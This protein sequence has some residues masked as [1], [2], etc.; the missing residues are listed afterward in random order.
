MPKIVDAAR[1]FVNWIRTAPARSSDI[2][3]RLMSMGSHRNKS[4]T[5]PKPIAANLRTFS[6]TPCAR[7]AINLIKNPIMYMDWEIQPKKNVPMN[8]EV[9]RQIRVATNCFMVPNNDDSFASFVEKIIED[10]LA[11]SAGAYEQQLGDDPTHPLWMWPV[12]GQSIQQYAMWDGSGP[13]YKQVLSRD[14]TRGIDLQ[15]EELVYITPN[16]STETPYGYGPLEIT[17]RSISRQ[18][19]AA[20]F[21]GNVAS[22]SQPLN[23]I[24]LGDAGP[25]EVKA[26]RS[27]WRD[28]VEGQGSTPLVGNKEK[29]AVLKLAGGDD[30]ALYLKWQE[31]LIAEIARGFDLSVSSFGLQVDSKNAGKAQTGVMQ[32]PNFKNAVVP[33]AMKVRDFINRKSIMGRLGF[34]QIELNWPAINA[35]DRKKQ[36]EI[37]EVRYQNNMLI[38]NEARAA[39]GKEPLDSE[40]GDMT[41][42]E[43]QIA[44]GEARRGNAAGENRPGILHNQS[45]SKTRQL[46]RRH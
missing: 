32:D 14:S 24:Y 13:R 8:S 38:P 10:I 7:R 42:A 9:R 43:V 31:F 22:N 33:M 15:D 17:A 5:Q 45:P 4:A 35:E 28:E 23:L 30:A 1:N 6:R 19:G 11:V 2:Y 16:P 21:A 39:E 25:E 3:P 46:T 20:E 41:Y 40:Y 26:F 37:D 29:P 34:T 27:F 12:D 18:L 36:A 44:I